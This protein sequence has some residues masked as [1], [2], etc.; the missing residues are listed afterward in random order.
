MNSSDPDSEDGS[1]PLTWPQSLPRKY[2]RFPSSNTN[3]LQ[4]EDTKSRPVDSTEINRNPTS[5]DKKG[6][7]KSLVSCLKVALCDWPVPDGGPGGMVSSIICW[8][9]VWQVT[10]KGWGD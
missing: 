8:N 1:R 4:S 9:I 3:D 6:G 2:P 7:K 5:E 10:R